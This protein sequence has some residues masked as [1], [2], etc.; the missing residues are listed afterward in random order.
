MAWGTGSCDGGTG[1]EALSLSHGGV[2]EDQV[3]EVGGTDGGGNEV[4][5]FFRT[6]GGAFKF[7]PPGLRLKLVEEIGH[8]NWGEEK[9]SVEK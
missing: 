5:C 7:D 4:L 1:E 8:V 9:R 6:H 3:D 2:A